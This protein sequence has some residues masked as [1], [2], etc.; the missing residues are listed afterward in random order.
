MPKLTNRADPLRK[1]HQREFLSFHI[2]GRIEVIESCFSDP[3]SI[4]YSKL[5]AAAIFSRSIAA[6]LGFTTRAGRLHSDHCY[7]PHERGKSWEVKLSDIDG[8]ACLTL[9]DLTL[10]ERESLENGINETNRAFAHLTYW[11]APADQDPRG[12]T[13]E[14]YRRAQVQRIRLFAQTVIDLLR[15]F[16]TGLPK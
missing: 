11:D 6:F 16:T 15:R 7:F 8:G 9:A 4:P 10:P 12:R 3:G 2:P 13:T 5:A 1:E 14:D